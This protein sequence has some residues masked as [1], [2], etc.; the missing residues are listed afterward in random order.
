MSS[1]KAITA[2]EHDVPAYEKR[3]VAVNGVNPL[4]EYREDEGYIID[5]ESG[6]EAEERRY[7]TAHDG[8][9]RLIPQPSD[10]PRDPLNWSWGKK[11]LILIV[12]ACAA[13]LPD[14][15]SATGAVTLIPQA[16]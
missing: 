14:Y 8:H 2:S 7:K 10:D 3:A 6:E 1:D 13:L 16:A 4:H 11:H 12:V 15:G 9:T 5:V